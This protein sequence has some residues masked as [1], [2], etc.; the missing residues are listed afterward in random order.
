MVAHRTNVGNSD[1]TP[2][3]DASLSDRIMVDR[4][5]GQL[6]DQDIL[7]VGYTDHAVELTAKAAI[8][9]ARVVLAA[10]G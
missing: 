2:P 4:L 5:S 10:G 9:G 3:V 8:A 6:V 1:W 7:I